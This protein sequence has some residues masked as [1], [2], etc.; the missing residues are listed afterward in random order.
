MSDNKPCPGRGKVVFRGRCVSKRTV[1]LIKDYELDNLKPYNQKSLINSLMDD[2]FNST[3]PKIDE[4]YLSEL[5]SQDKEMEDHMRSHT[6]D[7][8]D[9]RKYERHRREAMEKGIGDW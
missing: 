7:D 4:A 2:L 5:R 8:E 9:R 6:E 1:E 3:E